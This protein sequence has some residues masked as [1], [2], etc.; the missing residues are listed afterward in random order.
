MRTLRIGIALTAVAVIA[1]CGSSSAPGS[2][3]QPSSDAPSP[4][5]SLPATVAPDPSDPPREPGDKPP[6]T[7]WVSGSV[8]RGGQGPC[9]GFTA[10]DGTKYA[11][12][13]TDGLELTQ[14]DRMKVNLETTLIRIYCGPGTLM[15]MTA[16]EP[17]T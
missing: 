9:Y 1:G 15:A 10:D 6:A 7:G 2:A 4:A 12:Y 5:P 13:N 8:T 3:P 11:L 14:G 16:A 17:I